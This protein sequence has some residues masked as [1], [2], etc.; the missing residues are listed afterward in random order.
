MDG[1][2]QPEGHREWIGAREMAYAGKSE[3]AF[4]V[5]FCRLAVLARDEFWSFVRRSRLCSVNA[6]GELVVLDFVKRKRGHQPWHCRFGRRGLEPFRESATG[7]LAEGSGAGVSP[8]TGASRPW[9]RQRGRL[10]RANRRDAC[11]TTGP[12]GRLRQNGFH[13]GNLLRQFCQSR[14]SIGIRQ[15]QGRGR[16]GLDEARERILTRFIYV[17]E[18]GKE[19][20]KVAHGDRIE[21]VIVAM[22]ALKR[23]AQE[24][25]PKRVHPIINVGHAKLL[26]AGVR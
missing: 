13:A 17:L 6:V 8:A 21:F 22:G 1:G 3:P 23:Q 4:A 9:L 11:S 25:G 2:L 16:H 15:E 14:L 26:P 7:G 19:G 20:I 5:E 24:S 12:S 18:H 10:A